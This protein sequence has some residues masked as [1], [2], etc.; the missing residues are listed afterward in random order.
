MANFSYAKFGKNVA[1][2]Y[3]RED[4]PVILDKIQAART[5]YIAANSDI[6]SPFITGV[7]GINWDD[8]F[9]DTGYTVQVTVEDANFSM[10]S[11][12]VVVLAT[13][14]KKTPAGVTGR[15]YFPFGQAPP[16]HPFVINVTAI[17]D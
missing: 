16:N 11:P 15:L 3:T 13:G 4:L 1:S 2:P 8:Q 5:T 9:P 14:V 17:Q 12:A 7:W 10:N 6:S